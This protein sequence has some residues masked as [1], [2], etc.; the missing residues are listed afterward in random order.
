M[1]NKVTLLGRVGKKDYKSTK[2]G[3]FLC[4]LSIATSREYIDSNGNKV[5]NTTWHNVNFF[6]KLAEITNKFV[7]VGDLIY[8]EGE[9]SNRKV[10]ENG[11]NRMIHSI[12][13]NEVKFIPTGRKD[14]TI[15][16]EAHNS[17][18]HAVEPVLNMDEDVPF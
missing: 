18:Y 11:V 17:E 15:K 7:N 5:R 14:N 3:S 12:I 8:L 4:N 16:S 6:N 10:E 9:I 13:G 1:I 2:N